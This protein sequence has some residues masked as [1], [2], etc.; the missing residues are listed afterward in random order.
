MMI[1]IMIMNQVMNEGGCCMQ[2]IK[3]FIVIV[4]SLLIITPIIIL[5]NHEFLDEKRDLILLVKGSE[6]SIYSNKT[7]DYY[8]INSYPNVSHIVSKKFNETNI[9]DYSKMFFNYTSMEMTS[10]IEYEFKNNYSNERLRIDQNGCIHYSSGVSLAKINNKDLMYSREKAIDK[11]KEIVKRIHP[12]NNYILTNYYIVE[13][14]RNSLDGTR[15]LIGYEDQVII[16][17]QVVNG[18]NVTGARGEV[19]VRFGE[20]GTLLNYLDYT[21]P[22]DRIID[23]NFSMKSLDSALNILSDKKIGSDKEYTL[24]KCNHAYYVPMIDYSMIFLNYEIHLID[25]S[26]NE[27]KEYV[28][29]V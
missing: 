25:R 12:N 21:F 1:I 11:A 5:I 20:N 24:K 10:I 15:N 4:V 27:Y 13:C 19:S 18:I 29:L 9:M 16:F 28:E 23:D 6:I 17:R 26:G 3:V 14:H 22:V 8:Y 7:I 2:R